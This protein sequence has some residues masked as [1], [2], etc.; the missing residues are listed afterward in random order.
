MTSQRENESLDTMNKCNGDQDMTT[1]IQMAVQDTHGRWEQIGDYH[2]T[3]EA[4]AEAVRIAE[5]GQHHIDDYGV[6]VFQLSCGETI[7]VEVETGETW[8]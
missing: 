4:R 5:M 8:Q 3:D 2:S 1:T 7:S 6:M